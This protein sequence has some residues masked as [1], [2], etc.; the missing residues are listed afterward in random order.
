MTNKTA[1]SGPRMRI[2]VTQNEKN[3]A[4]TLKAEFKKIMSE[5]SQSVKILIKLRD[6]IVSQRPSKDDLENTYRGRLLRYRLTIREGFNQLLNHVKKSMELMNQ[7]SDPN[8][9]RLREV[10]MAEI[11]ELTNGV[12]SILDLL[13]EV[14]REGFTQALER[15]VAQIEKR[16]ESI[17]DIIDNQLFGHIEQNI[18]G[19]IKISD[20]KLKIQKRSRI[21]KQLVR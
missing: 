14:E 21:I 3:V 11:G 15:I 20:L 19:K 7:V 10:L 8:M 9:L 17:K 16:E 6:A 2:D 1:D 12:E 18:L 13:K 5:L 4:K